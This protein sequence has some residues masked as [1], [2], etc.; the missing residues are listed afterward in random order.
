M[1]NYVL[2]Y[3][4]VCSIY[5][6]SKDEQGTVSKHVQ[7]KFDPNITVALCFVDLQAVACLR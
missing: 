5:A 3:F 4:E 2:R 7:C 6:M 1:D